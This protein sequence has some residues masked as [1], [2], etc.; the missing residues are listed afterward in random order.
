[1][2]KQRD[3][4]GE[5]HGVFLFLSL[6]H[7]DDKRGPMWHVQCDCGARS[8]VIADRIRQ[9]KTKSCE[10]C[11]KPPPQSV[12]RGRGP[13]G[14]THPLN[15]TYRCWQNMKLRCTYAKHPRFKHY[16]GRGIKVC[17]RWASSFDAFLA[18]MGARPAGLTL[19]RIDVDGNYEP[20]NCRWA[21]RSEQGFNTQKH[22]AAA[23][24]AQQR[25]A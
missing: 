13:R 4:T 8:V 22:K 10:S 12:P 3:H 23:L 20:G 14:T 18:D 9:G 5:K 6:S 21:T 17:E 1:M 24:A 7:V 25:A 15:P 2:R 16:G 19:D 11:R